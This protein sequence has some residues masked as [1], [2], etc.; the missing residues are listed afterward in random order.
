MLEPN[1]DR[2]NDNDQ[3]PRKVSS[4]LISLFWRDQRKFHET[5][6]EG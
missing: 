4:R 3:Y 2:I 6:V 1:F 5:L